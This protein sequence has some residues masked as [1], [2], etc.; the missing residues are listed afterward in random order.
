MRVLNKHYIALINLP[1]T[2]FEEVAAELYSAGLI[3]IAVF[4]SIIKS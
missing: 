1:K 4:C 3:S 2:F